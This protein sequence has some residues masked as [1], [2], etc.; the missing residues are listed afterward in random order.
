VPL[1]W[2]RVRARGE[3]ECPLTF[4]DSTAAPT[5]ATMIEELRET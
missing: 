2:L 5:A 3:T 1:P 4:L